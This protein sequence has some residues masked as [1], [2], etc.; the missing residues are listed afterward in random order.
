MKRGTFLPELLFRSVLKYCKMFTRL[1]NKACE[2]T[3][4][5]HSCLASSISIYN[6]LFVEQAGGRGGPILSKL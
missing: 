1:S 4:V 5:S 2:I 3:V 6:D